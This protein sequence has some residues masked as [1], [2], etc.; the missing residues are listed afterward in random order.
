MTHYSNELTGWEEHCRDE[1]TA[2]DYESEIDRGGD[3]AEQMADEARAHELAVLDLVAKVIKLADD[4]YHVEAEEVAEYI[5]NAHK[6]RVL[7]GREAEEAKVIYNEAIP[8]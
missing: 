4:E 5:I 3:T 8:F 7:W 2:W 1:A 6:G